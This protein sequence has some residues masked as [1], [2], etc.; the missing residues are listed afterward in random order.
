MS[1]IVEGLGWQ[2]FEGKPSLRGLDPATP[3]AHGLV[4]TEDSFQVHPKQESGSIRTIVIKTIAY[5]IVLLLGGIGI[6]AALIWQTLPPFNDELQVHGLSAAASVRLDAN[7]IPWIRT[8]TMIDAATALGYLHARDRMFQMDLMRRSASGRLSEIAGQAAL[9]MDRMMR[10][11]G[12]RVRASSDLD[13]VSEPTR[14][15]WKLMRE[16]STPG[17]TNAAALARK[18]S[19]SSALQ[20][21]G[22]RWI[23]CFGARQWE[24][25]FRTTGGLSSPGS[26]CR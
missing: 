17:S 23:A 8:S 7:G 4:P 24:S 21:H 15:C 11:L 12:L 14:L 9:P 13:A 25:G 26:T 6:M 22:V 1:A 2:F 3:S 16:A 19:C 20:S 10:T 5:G 18:S